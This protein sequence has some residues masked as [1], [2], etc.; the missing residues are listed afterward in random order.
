MGEG[1]SAVDPSAMAFL[2]VEPSPV[3]YLVVADPRRRSRADT[4]GA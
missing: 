1:P 4:M 2:V 3:A